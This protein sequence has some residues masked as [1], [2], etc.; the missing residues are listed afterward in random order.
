[1]KKWTAA[2][3]LLAILFMAG[4]SRQEKAAK[5]EKSTE[6]SSSIVKESRKSSSKKASESTKDSQ[7]TSASKENVGS[8]SAQN[9]NSSVNDATANNAAAGNQGNNT[10]ADN[11]ATLQNGNNTT[12]NVGNAAAPAADPNNGAVNQENPYP[13]GVAADQVNNTYQFQGMNVPDTVNVDTANGTVTFDKGGTQD[14]YGA[15]YQEIPTRTIRVFSASDNSIRE[16]QVNS[17]VVLD[18]SQNPYYGSGSMYAFQ[19]SN[20]GVSLATPNYA[21][22][23]PNDQTDVML[24]VLP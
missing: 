21:G 24:E 11:N 12:N 16:V 8:S 7:K 9:P 1:M 22:N 13:Y 20:G 15:T 19:N 17:E 10:Q 3:G 18:G 23:V 2:V 14:V 6:P 5:S 4:C